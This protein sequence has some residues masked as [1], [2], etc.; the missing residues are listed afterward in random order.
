MDKKRLKE[1][2]KRTVIDFID[3]LINI[4]PQEPDLIFARIYINDKIQS[5]T[6]VKNFILTFMDGG[7]PYEKAVDEKNDGVFLDINPKI[8]G[9]IPEEKINHFKYIWRSGAVNDK[10]KQVIWKWLSSFVKIAKKFQ[11][12][13]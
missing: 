10:N 2:F 1:L 13:L 9:I 7:K 4:L 6:L 3:A 11:D 5:D 12:A 8:F